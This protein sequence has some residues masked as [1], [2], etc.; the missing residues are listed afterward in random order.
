M[1]MS[2]AATS[3][4]VFGVYLAGLSV[5]LLLAPNL[6]LGMFGIAA[7]T[8]VWIRV[9]GMLAA[10]LAFYNIQAARN[11][12]TLFIQWSVYIRASVIGFFIV[13]VLTGLAP[14]ALILFG[15]VDFVAALWTFIALR[16]DAAQLRATQA[17]S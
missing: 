7:T 10:F 11:E 13:F 4:F 2:R 15:I 1:A 5:L 12:L 9:V 14:P 17:I 8:E 16:Q 6:L 3:L